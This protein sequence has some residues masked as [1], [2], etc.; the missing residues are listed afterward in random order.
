MTTIEELGLLKMDFLGLR[1]LTVIRDALELIKT[2][3]NKDI[4]FETMS[5]D[6]PRVYEMIAK[7][8][9][10][11]V[12]QLESAGITQF[13]KNLK[14]DCFEDIIAG[15]S[16]YRP[17]P[18]ASIPTYIENK[19]NPEKIKYLHESLK[20]ILNVSYGCLV[21]QEQVMEIVRKVLR[22]EERRVGKECRSRW[23]PYH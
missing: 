7:G 5:Y 16:L 2:N 10:Q 3:H 1:N 17:G 21:Y 9:T 22:S 11:G 19:K 6:D 12:F 4:N 13:M 20:P 14:P 8:N 23:S 15:I 18:M